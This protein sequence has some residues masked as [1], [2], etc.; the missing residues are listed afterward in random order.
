MSLKVSD[1]Y[2]TLCSLARK[3]LLKVV[4]KIPL[5]F[6]V[7]SR[8]VPEQQLRVVY[9]CLPALQKLVTSLEKAGGLVMSHNTLLCFL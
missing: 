9:T 6:G 8:I 3:L 2:E 5:V 1:S 4:V 7:R